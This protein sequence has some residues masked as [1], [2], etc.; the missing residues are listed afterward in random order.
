MESSEVLSTLILCGFMGALGQGVRAA[1]GLKSAATIAAQNPT[2]HTEFDAAYFTL[3]LMIG[4]NGRNLGRARDR[5]TE[6]CEDRSERPQNAPRNYRR[7]LCWHRFYR[8]RIYQSC[9]EGRQ[10]AANSHAGRAQ[11]RHA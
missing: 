2:Q 9:P 8:E 5:V 3:S 7:W 6:I 4:F 11:T 1:V 10:A